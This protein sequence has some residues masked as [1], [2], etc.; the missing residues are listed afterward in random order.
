MIFYDR[1][2]IYNKNI[3]KKH[4]Q[5]TLTMMDNVLTLN[6]RDELNRLFQN[7]M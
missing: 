7:S 5:H 4:P 3:I 6:E 1:K 2:L